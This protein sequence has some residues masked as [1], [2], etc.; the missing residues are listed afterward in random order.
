MVVAAFEPTQIKSI[1]NRGTF[2]PGDPRILYSRRGPEY[3][4]WLQRTNEAIA[5][6]PVTDGVSGPA[7]LK[8][9]HEWGSDVGPSVNIGTADILADIERAAGLEPGFMRDPAHD[10]RFWEGEIATRL[11]AADPELRAEWERFYAEADVE[12]GPALFSRRA[13]DTFYS[14]VE[15][16]VDDAFGAAKQMKGRSLVASLKKR[17]GVKQSELDWLGIEAWAAGRGVVTRE[18]VRAFVKSNRVEIEEKVLGGKSPRAEA[19][20][21]AMQEVH[22][23]KVAAEA[24]VRSA[25]EGI[26]IYPSQQDT[27]IMGVY[28]DGAQP[29]IDLNNGTRIGPSEVSDLLH[30]LNK[31][32]EAYAFEE[33]LT[34]YLLASSE[35][36]DARREV[37]LAYGAIT[38]PQYDA[39][40]L[41][42]GENYRE[43]LLRL[44]PGGTPPEPLTTLPEG[45]EPIV[46]RNQ[47]ESRQW[48]ITPP[49]QIHARPWNGL[50]PTREAAIAD[51]LGRV[52][53]DRENQWRDQQPTYQAP[54]FSG[55]SENLLAHLRV[56]DRL[57]PKGER[58]LHVE[59]VQSDW[60]ADVRKKGVRGDEADTGLPVEVQPEDLS[61][62]ETEYQ[63]IV[64]HPDG[65][66]VKVGKGTVGRD[67]APSYGA[68]VL[69]RERLD[70]Q[71]E[72]AVKNSERVPP[73]PF[74][75][76]WH[77]LTMKV[78]LRMAVED[79]YDGVTWTTGKTQQD[80]YDLAK[81]VREV[82]YDPNGETL[83]AYDHDGKTVINKTVGIDEIDEYIGEKP[84]AKLREEV[85]RREYD[86]NSLFE[87]VEHPDDPDAFAIIN[88]NGDYT[89]DM[90]HPD[91]APERFVDRAGAEERI[92][93]DLVQE[94]ESQG[95]PS[96]SGLDLK[97]GGKWAEHLYDGM[98][99]GFLKRY[100]AKWDAKP[101]MTDIQV[102]IAKDTSFAHDRSEKVHHLPVTDAMRESIAEGQPQFS[103]RNFDALAF[104]TEPPREGLYD[105]VVTAGHRAAWDGVGMDELPE[106]TYTGATALDLARFRGRYRPEVAQA[107]T[108]AMAP[109]EQAA[110]TTPLPDLALPG[111]WADME[112]TEIDVRGGDTVSERTRA[113]F[114]R[115]AEDDYAGEHRPTGPEEGAPLHDLTGA[116][117]VY[118]DDV[119][120]PNGVRY[121][122]TGD[123]V[124]DRQA[125]AI[126]RAMKG[127]PDAK[128]TI[129][130]AVPKDNAERV[131]DI[132]HRMARI[133]KRGA[134]DP[135]EY[136]RLGAELERLRQAPPNEARRINPGDWV[137][138]TKAYAKDHGESALRGDYTILS[139]RVKAADIFTNGDSIH[140]WGYWPDGQRPQ[141]SRRVDPAP[142]WYSGLRR[143]VEGLKQ[144]RFTPDQLRGAL[145]KWQV[146][147]RVPEVK[148]GKP[149]M[150]GNE[151][152][153]RDGKMLATY[154]LDQGAEAEAHAARVGGVASF[155]GPA[156]V[157]VD[158][159]KWT[160]LNEFLEGKKTVTKAEVLAYLD[161][162]KVELGEVVLGT[163]SSALMDRYN[164]D[165][166][167]MED[168]IEKAR[169]V[170][171][172]VARDARR[173]ASR[174]R[175]AV[176]ALRRGW[177]DIDNAKDYLDESVSIEN[178][179]GDSPTW[180]PVR[181]LLEDL[182]QRADDQH[183]AAV[184][185]LEDAEPDATDTSD[186]P[187]ARLTDDEIAQLEAA[188]E[189]AALNW[190][191]LDWDEYVDVRTR[192][193]EHERIDVSELLQD[194]TFAP[195][196]GPA[197]YASLVL[198][199]DSENYRELLFKMP[200]GLLLRMTQ[201]NMDLRIARLRR[202]VEEGVLIANQTGVWPQGHRD[203]QLRLAKAQDD[204]IS[205]PPYRSSHFPA[206]G[207]GENL[208]AHVRF[209]DRVGP[210]GEKIL[211]I[212][213]VQSDLHQAGR[214]KGYKTQELPGE[215]EQALRARETVA[216]AERTAAHQAQ[217]D[218]IE[219]YESAAN[220]V[221]Q[222]ETT[223]PR[224]RNMP[225]DAPPEQVEQWTRDT[226][227]W[228]DAAG[229]IFDRKREAISALRRA[230][231]Q[232]F[233]LAG[234]APNV[235]SGL[236]LGG[237]LMT[238]DDLRAMADRQLERSEAARDEWA[239]NE[240]DAFNANRVPDAPFAKT[241]HEMV[242][243]RMLRF[244]AENDY[245]AV[246]WTTGVQQVKRYEDQVRKVVDE[247]RWRKEPM[248]PYLWRDARETRAMDEYGEPWSVLTPKEQAAIT[249]S[250]GP[251]AESRIVIEAIKD[252]RV[253]HNDA[254]S[255]TE[256]KGVIGGD[257]VKAIM[258]SPE[259]S[260]SL[261]GP[262]LTVGGQGMIG[263]Y[264]KMLPAWMNK[265]AAKW[266]ARVE[267][268]DIGLT[269]DM[270]AE[271]WHVFRQSTGEDVAQFG[272]EQDAASY[273][274]RA[275]QDGDPDL[276][277]LD[278]AQTTR[279]ADPV[280]MIRLTPEM[281]RSVLEQGQAQFSRRA[282]S[283]PEFQEWSR[284]LPVINFDDVEAIPE[285][286][287]IVRAFHGSRFDNID[288]FRQQD[289]AYGYFFSPDAR[290]ADFYRG[291][292]DG[293][294][295]RYE[296]YLRME[297]PA[298]FNDPAVFEAV[299]KEAIWDDDSGR[300]VLGRYGEMRNMENSDFREWLAAEATKLYGSDAAVK[301]WVD[302]L[303]EQA[304]EPLVGNPDA[305]R[306]A[307]DYDAID[308]YDIE[309]TLLS[310][311]PAL[312]AALDE[313]MPVRSREID[314][315]R[316]A[317]NEG[318]QNWYMNYQDDFVKA[319]EHMG[320]DS[321]VMTD[322][323][324]EGAP[325]SFVVFK[326]EQIKD[327]A[328]ERP[329]SDPRITHSRRAPGAPLTGQ[330]FGAAGTGTP[331]NARWLLEFFRGA[332]WRTLLHENGHL[333][334]EFIGEDGRA[335]LAV[336]YDS[337]PQHMVDD[338]H[339]RAN[340][341]ESPAQIAT[342]LGLE[343]HVEDMN[344][345][346]IEPDVLTV[347]NVL[348]A[349]PGEPVLTRLGMDQAADAFRRYVELRMQP[350]G[351]LGRAVAEVG[352][353]LR[354]T[355]AQF[356][357]QQVELPAEV[358]ASWDRLLRPEGVAQR[359]LVVIGEA[360]RPDFPIVRVDPG[361]EYAVEEKIRKAGQAREAKRTAVRD[362]ELLQELGLEVG[363]QVP[364]DELVSKVAAYMVVEDAR[365]WMIGVDMVTLTPR[366]V[367][368]KARLGRVRK[369]ALSRLAGALGD[370][371]ANL[372]AT[373]REGDASVRLTPAQQSG[374][375]IYA[376]QLASEPIATIYGRS[377]V[378]ERL[379]D[380]AANLDTITF[381][382]VNRLQELALDVEAGAATRRT[383]RTASV[384][385]SA[386]AA[387]VDVLG[388][389]IPSKLKNTLTKAFIVERPMAGYPD[390]HVQ[391][392]VERHSRELGGAQDWVR[393]GVRAQRAM[394][395]WYSRMGF[396]DVGSI[397]ESL[398]GV[399]NE[400]TPPVARNGHDVGIVDI[401]F[402]QHQAL[403]G[404]A[405]N[406][407]A[408]LNPVRLVALQDALDSWRH[409]LSPEE[410]AALRIL[411]SYRGRT[412]VNLAPAELLDVEDAV[413]R[414]AVGLG[415]RVR[416]VE[417]RANEIAII[418]T[419]SSE[420]NILATLQWYDR[421][422][423][424][425]A[426]YEG[427]WLPEHGPQVPLPNRPPTLFD[428][429]A[430]MGRATG[431]ADKSLWRRI[432][433]AV[434][435][436]RTFKMDPNVALA[437]AIVRMRAHDILGRMA[438]ELAE[439]GLLGPERGRDVDVGLPLRDRFYDHVVAALN[440]RVAWNDS[441][442]L[443]QYTGSV[444][445][446]GPPAP[447][448]DLPTV[449]RRRLAG[450]PGAFH[451]HPDMAALLYADDLMDRWGWKRGEGLWTAMDLDGRRIMVPQMF[452]EQIKLALDEAATVGTA[453][454]SGQV[455]GTIAP[456][457]EPA[458]GA[459]VGSRA[460]LHAENALLVVFDAVPKLFSRIKVGMVVGILV[461][462]VFSY[463]GNILDGQW[464]WFQRDGL[465]AVFGA[466]V[467]PARQ[468]LVKDVFIG[469]WGE[470]RAIEG[471]GVLVTKDG[472]V[473]SAEQ[474]RQMARSYGLNS[475]FVHAESARALTDDIRREHRTWIENV[476]L[477]FEWWQEQLV[478]AYTAIDNYGRL[479]VFFDHLA[480]GADPAEAAAAARM[481]LYDYGNMTDFEQRVM[482]QV[483]LFYAYE[484]ANQTLFWWTLLNHPSRVAGQVRLIR[485]MQQLYLEDE[486]RIVRP[487][488]YERQLMV[489]YRRFIEDG[490]RV[491]VRGVDVEADPLRRLGLAFV[492]RQQPAVDGF[493]LWGEIISWALS[494]FDDPKA[495]ARVANRLPPWWQA[496]IVSATR[497]DPS[498]SYNIDS[499]NFNTVP[500]WFIALDRALTGGLIVDD[501]LGVR[502]VDEPDPAKRYDVDIPYRW[503][504][505]QGNELRWW[506]IQNLGHALPGMGRGIS[507]M[508]A[509]DRSFDHGPV[510]R[511]VRGTLA[512][513]EALG[514]TP[515]KTHP[516]IRETLEG[517]RVGRTPGDEL[518]GFFI[519]KPILVDTAQELRRRDTQRAAGKAGA[520]KRE[521]KRADNP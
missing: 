479:H 502:P 459:A 228:A 267:V 22:R 480:K 233:E 284:G 462:N 337:L 114:S 487:E 68:R 282:P 431:L 42:G 396:K 242:L 3:D 52:N 145:G 370:T 266:G 473:Y 327:I 165:P 326:P 167:D 180:E 221:T 31:Y 374:L 420:A 481:A 501:F 280:H 236:Y 94:D 249:A 75:Q 504:V 436:R 237:R 437:E 269:R 356:R 131:G 439:Y 400:L 270:P 313:A 33:A 347:E 91:F 390:P 35:W 95:Y 215:M 205:P 417:L 360:G 355:W 66:E 514:L 57:G 467:N 488:N 247:I 520:D 490:V 82:A 359:R 507:T 213:E 432:K 349:T 369:A 290:T 503:V 211:H 411:D 84:G 363:D 419:G 178:N 27:R 86:R 418:L 10:R 59:E 393:N 69:N 120:G 391:D 104:G 427:R 434:Q 141:F 223:T 113:R 78:A 305:L 320:Y 261:K 272:T 172:K 76:D 285:G 441:T 421:V 303:A 407:D 26:A 226:Q 381:A 497:V 311:S 162:N 188:V 268:G 472:R 316:A 218:A 71:R 438:D 210:N 134:S 29:M 161:K 301:A 164:V 34:D 53:S 182:I 457:R 54:H 61:V 344:G 189:S 217:L 181:S 100:A 456:L 195:S 409:G 20:K 125:F 276:A 18:E 109:R 505:G 197:Q 425:K 295:R 199:G 37:E 428:I 433:D 443:D 232:R 160:R 130:R 58:L 21:T 352:E 470:Q 455:V 508:Q 312:K 350:T 192:D 263:F 491:D 146:K 32:V 416:V 224:P 489:A 315:A 128:V 176:A 254:K 388:R 229:D 440:A 200:R 275:A 90:N 377:L 445:R 19:A 85:K 517:P 44:N 336:Y 153:M 401:L 333:L 354:E 30:R 105:E 7:L 449:D 340:A 219:A 251:G 256:M 404:D 102:P 367:I 450:P 212:E 108:G 231:D 96:I 516:Y 143:A 158:E 196:E 375:R 281:R 304:G 139:A 204:R 307:I 454:R 495:A 186:V 227:A 469:L 179:Y 50:H 265:Y 519:A 246:S 406:V 510:E 60:A 277:G 509:L 410:E 330:F 512:T 92:N 80:R 250:M 513:R 308:E 116:G 173:A 463:I 220:A 444:V 435:G 260:G 55:M 175:D 499:G 353:R 73:T 63:W 51:A 357:G 183:D 107:D 297:N 475:S 362:E 222:Y 127:R 387:F 447:H 461:P 151:P 471:R 230:F 325:I 273:V 184:D 465:R 142:I 289:T 386:A 494:A 342:A 154:P 452:Q 97:I 89:L 157:K 115:R 283:T 38:K 328:N 203:A 191:G 398:R 123:E 49:G 341:G 402:A 225:S 310:E 119:Y 372:V 133:L 331:G 144:D 486:Y 515:G 112:V 395:P 1:S 415:D 492:T 368:P 149:V 257:M 405:P 371:P 137:T 101:G 41:P 248:S 458:P 156:G 399:A 278:Y 168:A 286:G 424:Y 334:Q 384:S 376:R 365:K 9:L 207:E 16:S 348:R 423:L 397:M 302:D 209:N 185:A 500:P 155:A 67:E 70:M 43:V 214:E 194:G 339:Q 193:G 11:M 8:A 448:Q 403:S 241:W 323:S 206:S 351:A 394:R 255:A 466:Q 148:D 484:R 245:D 430:G 446:R 147:E 426:F 321:V 56:N 47:P 442:A 6:M 373:A 121:Y 453:R 87:V 511:L 77:E 271:N 65:R 5:A 187:D 506:G 412:A 253:V 300:V 408:I 62:A 190:T 2:D 468:K 464:Q 208:L 335:L 36:Q 291:G 287:A 235:P 262:D 288:E 138:I 293:V 474:L 39:H 259:Q 483:S 118:P 518:V 13:Q 366:T 135:G 83:L 4:R 122:G 460:A 317:H 496:P 198:S 171:R 98:I 166:S 163:P 103:R 306:D 414:I 45:Y 299:A 111:E 380:P 345:T 152:V 485:D 239:R 329:T 451:G 40:V 106:S 252:G 201:A 12:Y 46:D 294:G 244:A 14:A 392:I 361:P 140:E 23:R 296:V 64:S 170:E 202:Q 358:R 243:K 319:A 338:I 93:Y 258:A 234:G 413:S 318:S 81:R 482:R 136:D 74:P 216:L 346:R 309:N 28:M 48:G 279:I 177:Q 385:P 314:A 129:Y 383:R 169:D 498:T 264:D 422:A 322:P 174:G 379:L 429:M 274:S 378:P 364:L 389:A 324:P 478:S 25:V 343:T 382:E 24:K 15:R 126:A 493:T 292:G 79:G 132:E 17:P 117:V 238:P 150:K 332:D 159:V 521:L 240:F 298:D 476:L 124:L 99:P 477:P 110:T 88:T 72:I